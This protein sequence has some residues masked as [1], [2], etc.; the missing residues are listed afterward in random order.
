[1]NSDINI[2]GD[3]VFNYKQYT[4]DRFVHYYQ[5]I[6]IILR[7]KPSKVLEIGPG[8]H[9]VTDFFKRKGVYIKT[10]DNDKN[11][12]PD[13]FV[14]IKKEVNIDEKFDLV[15][16][17]EVLEHNKFERLP[18]IICNLKKCLTSNGYMVISVPYSTLRLFP[19]HKYNDGII[20]CH[21][22]IYT[23]LPYCRVLQCLLTVIRGGYRL[24]FKRKGVEKIFE[25]FKALEYPDEV[26]TV[27]HWDAGFYPTTIKKIREILLKEFNI[28]EQKIYYNTNCVFFVVQKS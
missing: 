10:A 27:H 9:T 12:H 3:S 28:I 22:V 7:L 17:A 19:P 1:M 8:D 25:Y 13:Y 24:L 23:Y 15:L 18:S 4:A 2:L 14:D 5:Q 16:A 20:S 6:E 21:G 26:T 11:L